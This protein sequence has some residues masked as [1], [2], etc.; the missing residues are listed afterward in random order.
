MVEMV[1]NT[2]LKDFK[3]NWDGGASIMRAVASRDPSSGKWGVSVLRIK[4]EG[5]NWYI[6][7]LPSAPEFDTAEDALEAAR[8]IGI[9]WI[10]RQLRRGAERAE[11][12]CRGCFRRCPSL[13]WGA[14]SRG[15]RTPC[16]HYPGK[17]VG[18]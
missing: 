7:D 9:Q 2:E 5:K 17:S 13:K 15:S 1:G 6:E 10:R 18:V 4:G 3:F 12:P 8:Q 14:C 11:R 16:R